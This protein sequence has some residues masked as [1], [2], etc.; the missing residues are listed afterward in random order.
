MKTNHILISLILFVL[1][2]ASCNSAARVGE[3]Q[4]KSQSVE[5]GDAKSVRVEINMGA[6][7]LQVTGGADRLL[8]SDFVYNVAKLKP[9]VM[10]SY[11]TLVIQQPDTNGLPVLQGITDFRN[12]WDLHLNDEVPM[13]LRLEMGAGASELRLASLSLTGLDITLGAGGSTIDLSGNWARDLDV[14]IDAG[15]V[16]RHPSGL[17]LSADAQFSDAYHSS[18]DNSSRDEIDP[19][20][21]V[22]A[23]AGYRWNENLRG[24]AFVTNIFDSSDE[25]LLE[26]G[27]TLANDAAS[28]LRPRTFGVGLQV[29]F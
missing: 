19:Y 9:E 7:N 21:V 3:L 22:N 17:E 20:V 13:D 26:P 27:A 1:V 14:T 23:Q 4:T 25:L 24:F 2:L 15:A 28:I 12:E 29:N 5:L 10:Y 18:I 8:E 11:G 6:G 16:Y